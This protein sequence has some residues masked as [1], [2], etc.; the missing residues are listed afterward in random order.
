MDRGV[1][2]HAALASLDA[3]VG[4]R[5]S[6]ALYALVQERATQLNYLNTALLARGEKRET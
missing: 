1:P 2:G 5:F 6:Q 3:A 4:R